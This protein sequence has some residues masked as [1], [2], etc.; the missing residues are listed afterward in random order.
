MGL[1]YLRSRY[2]NTVI[3]RF[4]NPDS[5]D[6]I[7]YRN[8]S[9]D[10][11]KYCANNPLVFTD[12]S[13][14]SEAVATPSLE[15]ILAQVIQG[16]QILAGTVSKAVPGLGIFLVTLLTPAHTATDAEEGVATG[17]WVGEQS[18]TNT[19]SQNIGDY[20]GAKIENHTFKQI[21]P[22]MS[23][24]QAVSWAFL[25]SSLGIDNGGMGINTKWGIYT[26]SKANALAIYP[27]LLPAN[28]AIPTPAPV[29]EFNL[30]GQYPHFHMPDRLFNNKHKHFHIWYGT[31]GGS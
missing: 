6:C 4:I 18:K 16:A 17:I 1:Y 9:L 28:A 22:A 12:I 2:Y 7:L 13:G 24:E 8:S 21:T 3:G 10:A 27:L 15:L 20:Y 29:Y 14:E 23:I 25:V 5:V 30:P 31:I 11:F 26:N 19:K